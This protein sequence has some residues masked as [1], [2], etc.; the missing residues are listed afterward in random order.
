MEYIILFLKI[1]FLVTA[2]ILNGVLCAA[3]LS[4]HRRVGFGFFLGVLLGPVGLLCSLILAV[5]WDEKLFQSY[6]VGM[7][8]ALPH[9][10]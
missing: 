8:R 9:Q 5:R 2:V 3:I 6:T 4:K 10:S 1:G 7:N